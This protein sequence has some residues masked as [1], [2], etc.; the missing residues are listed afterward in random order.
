MA[1]GANNEGKVEK[2]KEMMNDE[3]F[4][5]DIDALEAAAG[6]ER[7]TREELLKTYVDTYAEGWRAD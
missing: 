7:I 2:L 4:E 5:L 3:N 6:G 1:N